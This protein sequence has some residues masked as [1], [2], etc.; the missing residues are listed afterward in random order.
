MLALAAKH[1]TELFS[2]ILLRVYIDFQPDVYPGTG[3]KV[4]CKFYVLPGSKPFSFKL[5]FWN[6][7]KPNKLVCHYYGKMSDLC[8]DTGGEF[9][10]YKA[11][12]HIVQQMGAGVK[13]NFDRI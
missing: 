12:T 5:K 9:C 11:I 6:W 7:T 10:I 4:K 13:I 2:I 3:R 8:P 1:A